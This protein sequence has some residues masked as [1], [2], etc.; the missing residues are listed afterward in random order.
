MWS[1]PFCSIPT[2]R[3]LSPDLDPEPLLIILPLIPLW[4]QFYLGV[5]VPVCVTLSVGQL[6]CSAGPTKPWWHSGRLWSK[7]HQSEYSPVG[8]NAQL[9]HDVGWPRL[10]G[11]SG[12]VALQSWGPPCE[13]HSCPASA[14]LKWVWVAA[15]KV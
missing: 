12:E 6:N 14:S 5:L 11:T 2:L 1:V 15:G 4:C 7:H 3:T 10:G 9:S 13:A 8:G